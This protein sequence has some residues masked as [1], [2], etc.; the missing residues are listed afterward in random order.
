MRL[1]TRPAADDAPAPPDGPRGPLHVLVDRALVVGSLLVLVVMWFGPVLGYVEGFSP[2]QDLAWYGWRTE[3]LLEQPPGGLVEWE[4][5]LGVFGGGYRVATPALGGL[6]RGVAGLTGEWLTVALVSG[7]LVLLA[8]LCGAIAYR[9]TKSTSAFATTALFAGSVFFL[10]PYVGYVDNGM[11][12]IFS[13]SALLLLDAARRALSARVAVFILVLMAFFFHPPTALLFVAATVVSVAV[14]AAVGPRSTALWEEVRTVGVAVGAAAVA[15]AAWSIGIWGPNSGFADAAHP[16]PLSSER[17]FVTVRQWVTQFQPALVIPLLLVGLLVAIL[18]VRRFLKD[19]T[20]RTAV[21]WLLPIIGVLGYF[22]G[23]RYPFHRFLNST[24]APVVIAGMGLWGTASAIAR[25]SRRRRQPIDDPGVRVRARSGGF[26]AVAFV[27]LILVSMWR[28]DFRVF[29]GRGPWLTRELVASLTAVRAYLEID[30]GHPVVLP[31]AARAD[32][33][34]DVLW[35]EFKAW[36]N[37]LRGAVPGATLP[38]T[39][40][41]V[42][43]VHDVLRGA[44]RRS[45]NRLL[46]RIA[47]ATQRAAGE[48]LRGRA[49]LVILVREANRTVSNLA[50]FQRAHAVKADLDVAIVTRPG[51]ARPDPDAL[52]AAREAGERVRAAADPV[53]FQ[54]L[55]AQFGRVW[56]VLALVAVLPGWLI[57]RRIGISDL[58][59]IVALVPALSLA[60]HAFVSIVMLAVLRRPLSPGTGAIIVGVSIG[61]SLV[62]SRPWRSAAPGDGR[63][64]EQ[65]GD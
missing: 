23:L 52:R 35:G 42:G 56:F 25:V 7:R 15:F 43:N 50:Y 51:L 49:P 29:D 27:G 33:S 46:D 64:E 57:A 14:R 5:P 34:D 48:T 38:D 58:A 36:T 40:V 8:L 32:A 63:H 11:A 37:R 2:G 19:A 20:R 21:I 10:Y 45:G 24:P 26:L 28:T 62:L 55:A 53:A 13:A 47:V 1:L 39:S 65:Q 44:A 3:F 12:M 6:L 4:G 30:A 9:L 22:A 31:V 41:V 61:L 59:T 18:P 54:T 17:F 60:L 16:P